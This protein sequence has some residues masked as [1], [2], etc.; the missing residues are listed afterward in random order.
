MKVATQ[1]FVL[2]TLLLLLRHYQLASTISAALIFTA[3]KQRIVGT[4]LNTQATEDAAPGID[5][6]LLHFISVL[7][8]GCR[9]HDFDVALRA[10][11]STGSTP[12]TPFLVPNQLIAPKPLRDVKPLFGV[13]GGDPMPQK[14]PKGYSQPLSQP[15]PI[16]LKL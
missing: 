12:G 10:A 15:L 2:C 6:K 1:L 14:V 11:L 13:L 5:L 4:G 8:Y 7:I 9:G 16:V 3:V